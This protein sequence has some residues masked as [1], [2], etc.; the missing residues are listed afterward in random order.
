MSHYDTLGVPRDASS[1]AI[2]KAYRAAALRWHPDKNPENREEAERKFIDVAA[3]YEVL[4]DERSRAAYDAGGSEHRGG[5]GF[6]FRRANQMFTANFGEALA[7]QWRPGSRVTGMLV[8]DGKRITIT[9]HPDGTSDESEEAAGRGRD[10]TYVS[11]S[12]GGGGSHTQIQI[13]GSLGQ[14]FADFVLPQAME[15]IPLVG[16]AA[17]AGLSWVPTIAC[18]GCC[19][20][21]CWKPL[22]GRSA[23]EKHA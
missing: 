5:G 10:Y 6:D 7:Q 9:I 8:R 11:Q 3:A 23:R 14:A 16:D 20:V 13:T 1:A 18:V 2:R 12:G 4:S 17:S 19:Y 15:R 22:C 21:C